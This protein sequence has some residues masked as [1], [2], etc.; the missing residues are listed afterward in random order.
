[1][2]ILLPA[3]CAACCLFAAPPKKKTPVVTT[4]KTVQVGGVPKSQPST[5]FKTG[6][7]ALDLNGDGYITRQEYSH[8]RQTSQATTEFNAKD[9]DHDG[10][11]SRSE[12]K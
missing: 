6:F 2:K 1:M 12:Y 3:I 5:G 7:A 8:N 10:R 4:K 11:I 9:L